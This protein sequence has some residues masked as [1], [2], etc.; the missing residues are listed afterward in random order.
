[1]KRKKKK[2]KFPSSCF[3]TPFSLL[4]GELGPY[5][6]C[7]VSVSHIKVTKINNE[8]AE[9]SLPNSVAARQL[10]DK[11]WWSTRASKKCLSNPCNSEMTNRNKWAGFYIHFTKQRG[12]TWEFSK[13]PVHS[14]I[15]CKCNSSSKKAK[16]VYCNALLLS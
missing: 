12:K 2:K 7:V 5:P 6:F 1:M 15:S 3:C 8:A 4:V 10:L 9:C 14:E 11:N 16:H 13:M